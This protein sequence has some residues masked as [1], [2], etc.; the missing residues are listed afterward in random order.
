[1]SRSAAQI[2]AQKKA[3][4]ASAAKRKSNKSVQKKLPKALDTLE[5]S[6]ASPA[7]KAARAAFNK[8]KAAENRVPAGYKG[9]AEANARMSASRHKKAK[10]TV[11]R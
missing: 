3:A 5:N 2:A 8:K 1:M 9:M 4:K 11:N 7:E 6:F 10:G